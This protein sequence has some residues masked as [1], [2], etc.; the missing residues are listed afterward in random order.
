MKKCVI[1]IMAS[2]M[3]LAGC[4]GELPEEFQNLGPLAPY[5]K[6]V[7]SKQSDDSKDDDDYKKKDDDKTLGSSSSE[8][9]SNSD[10]DDSSSASDKSK[11]D[12]DK[13]ISLLGNGSGVG[14]SDLPSSSNSD[15]DKGHKTPAYLDAPDTAAGIEIAGYTF[16]F[17]DDFKLADMEDENGVMYQT[18]DSTAAIIIFEETYD[19]DMLE[20]FIEYQDLYETLFDETI[21]GLI[22]QVLI[23]D[24][25]DMQAG[26]MIDDDVRPAD[27][28]GNTHH[29]TFTDGLKSGVA[30]DSW[31]LNPTTGE[32]AYI[33]LIDIDPGLKNSTQFPSIIQNASFR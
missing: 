12:I 29:V 13:Y 20:A 14:N 16:D 22:V 21:D 31:F 11:A 4:T 3:L 15:S 25:D 5:E 8:E 17:S 32:F 1:A 33:I 6:E 23:G 10:D 27:A 24:S 9:K 30:Y 26:D 18:E 2:A 7:A 19:E 28:I